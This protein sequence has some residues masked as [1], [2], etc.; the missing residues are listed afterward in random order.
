MAEKGAQ[1]ASAARLGNGNPGGFII[2]MTA[3]FPFRSKSAGGAFP[4]AP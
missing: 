4:F 2:L 3:M 1:S